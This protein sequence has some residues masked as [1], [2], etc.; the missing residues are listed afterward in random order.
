MDAFNLAMMISPNLVK[1]S[2]PIRDV[3]MCSVPLPTSVTGMSASSVAA[4]FASQE[5]DS[6]NYN[7]NTENKTTLGM[8]IAFCIRRYYE[9]FDEIT[10]RS[11]AVAPW[12]TLV[13]SND[14]DS[15]DNSE[16]GSGTYVLG[17]DEELDDDS[18]VHS[19]S[20]RIQGSQSALA[21]LGPQTPKVPTSVKKHKNSLSMPV[22]STNERAISGSPSAWN[23]SF[24]SNHVKTRSLITIEGGIGNITTN[25]KGSIAIGRGTTRK[26]SGSAVE[27]VSVTAEG[28]FTP[29]GN[30]L[31]QISSSVSAS[32][33]TTEQDA[34]GEEA[35]IFSVNERKRMFENGGS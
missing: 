18:N 35:A 32:S 24:A 14:G 15:N 1:G 8:V 28:L 3:M 2:N 17:E 31:V 22:Q 33:P 30:M 5:S 19:N 4:R 6:P 20:Q 27:A 9:I 16:D 25:R 13:G 12:K 34:D 7:E 11:E 10:D 26:G 29:P 23:K 21:S